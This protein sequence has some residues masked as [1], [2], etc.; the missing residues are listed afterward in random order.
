MDMHSPHTLHFERF[1]SFPS[2]LLICIWCPLED[3]HDHLNLD[4]FWTNIKGKGAQTVPKKYISQQ[5]KQGNKGI[6]ECHNKQAPESRY[7]ADNHGTVATH[8]GMCAR[9]HYCSKRSWSGHTWVDHFKTHQ[10]EITRDDCCGPPLDL[11]SIKLEEIDVT[12]IK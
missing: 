6:Y 4:I 11:T 12:D 1:S 3:P 10:L 5:L 9:C 8:M 7:P 2:I